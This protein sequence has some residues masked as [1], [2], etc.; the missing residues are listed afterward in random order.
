MCAPRK[1]NGY[2]K[3]E[4]QSQNR[5]HERERRT[6]FVYICLLI[7]LRG[8]YIMTA[9]TCSDVDEAAQNQYLQA[10]NTFKRSHM[11]APVL[12]FCA[13]SAPRFFQRRTHM[14]MKLIKGTLWLL[15]PNCKKKLH[16]VKADAECHGVGTNCKNCGWSGFINIEN[17][18]RKGQQWQ[19]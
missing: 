9:Q 11:C 15:C 12:G 19:A 13:P 8:Q 3:A 10:F 1:T 7:L 18:E 5:P 16:P 4:K 17:E 2:K 14:Q 6:F